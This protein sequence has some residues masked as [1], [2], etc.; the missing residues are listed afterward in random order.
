M[1]TPA[2][3]A[4]ADAYHFNQ[5]ASVTRSNFSF[6]CVLSQNC[7]TDVAA[8]DNRAVGKSRGEKKRLQNFFRPLSSL[9]AVLSRLPLSLLPPF[10][11]SQL[12]S[13][14]PGITPTAPRFS[15]GPLARDKKKK[16][17]PRSK[18]WF[19]I[20]NEDKSEILPRRDSWKTNRP[21]L[22]L[23]LFWGGVG[24][25]IFITMRSFT[26]WAG[27]GKVAGKVRCCCCK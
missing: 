4:C 6:L 17:N 5:R 9:I 24:G 20:G 21:P 25:Q 14:H 22:T 15:G 19:G 26:R 27:S 8:S 18:M 10:F 13:V 2:A 12:A 11:L 7:T 16:K 3:H 1:A 23:L